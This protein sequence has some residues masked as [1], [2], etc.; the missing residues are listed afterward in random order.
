[1]ISFLPDVTQEG[2]SS[3]N[4]S[5]IKH[6]TGQLVSLVEKIISE[7]RYFSFI[8]RL[9]LYVTIDIPKRVKSREHCEKLFSTINSSVKVL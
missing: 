3:L 5:F 7:K 2:R 8:T 9:P 4:L 1:M 6:C